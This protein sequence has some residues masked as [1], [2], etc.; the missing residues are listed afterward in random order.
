MAIEIE[1][2]LNIRSGHVA[3]LRH[4]SLLKTMGQ[5]KPRRQKLYSIYFDTPEQDLLQA[6]I[7]LRLRR[8]GGTWVQTVKGG[9]GA[10]GG[11]TSATSGN[12]RCVARNRKWWRMLPLTSQHG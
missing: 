3:R 2:K 6:G 5:G 8:V 10:Q 9:G 4:H 11:C 7:A 1:L 12:G